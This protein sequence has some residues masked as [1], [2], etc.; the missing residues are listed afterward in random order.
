MFWHYN[1]KY[2]LQILKVNN[3]FIKVYSTF[4]THILRLNAVLIIKL[5]NLIF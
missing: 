5:K 4:S 1:K 2:S 3:I